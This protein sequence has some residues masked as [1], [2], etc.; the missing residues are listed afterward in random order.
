RLVGAIGLPA[1]DGNSWI[2]A[3]PSKCA[4]FRFSE[5]VRVPST[6]TLAKF[7]SEIRPGRT[8][9]A[10]P[11]PCTFDNLSLGLWMAPTEYQ[12]ESAGFPTAPDSN[13]VNPTIFC[14]AG[15]KAERAAGFQETLVAGSP[16]T[17]KA[18]P[19]IPVTSPST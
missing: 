9:G 17:S 19:A 1:A 11:I 10:I 15:S 6:A 12:W 4:K 13:V 7:I 2:S 16:S 8:T 18:N 14:V 5:E 3:P